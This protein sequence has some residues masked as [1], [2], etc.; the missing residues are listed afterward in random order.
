MWGAIVLPGDGAI[1]QMAMRDFKRVELK[2]LRLP[3]DFH[4]PSALGG[5]P[6]RSMAE[7]DGVPSEWETFRED[8]RERQEFR[9]GDEQLVARLCTAE[10]LQSLAGPS[11]FGDMGS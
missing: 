1:R 8:P 11:A 2:E 10:S 7:V 6:V 4:M 9:S 5:F 3:H